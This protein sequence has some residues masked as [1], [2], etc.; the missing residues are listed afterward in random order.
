MVVGTFADRRR[1]TRHERGYGTAWDKLRRQVLQ[2][3][4]GLCQVCARAGRVM[5]AH[6]VD[7]VVPKAAG[8]TDDQDNLQA[9]CR[10][11]HDAKTSEEKRQGRG[12]QKV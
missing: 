3:D 12:V 8:G 1:G 10:P 5:R 9:I 4:A 2:R 7:H 6:A 11:C